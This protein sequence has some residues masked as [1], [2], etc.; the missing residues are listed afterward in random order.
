MYFY[1]L[2]SSTNL[3]HF[4]ICITIFFYLS[5]FNNKMNSISSQMFGLPGL[6]CTVSQ[7]CGTE[8]RPVVELYGPQ[9][10][11]RYLRTSLELSR[12]Q[13]GY[14]YVVHELVP[15]AEQYPADWKVVFFNFQIH[16]RLYAAWHQICNR[17]TDK[18]MAT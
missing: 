1:K 13:L 12:S 10:L 16:L 2:T 17:L 6:M 7:T 9:G 8:N 14:N 4:C 15:V 3:R 5:P 18:M 11:Q